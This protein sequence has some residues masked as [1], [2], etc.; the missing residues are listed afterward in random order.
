[1][2]ILKVND[3]DNDPASGPPWPDNYFIRFNRVKGINAESFWSAPDQRDRVAIQE[4][5]DNYDTSW[6]V[7]ALGAGE[8]YTIAWP[9]AP[10]NTTVRV[11]SID[12][13]AEP[14]RAVV[15]LK[16]DD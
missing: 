8:N 6:M 4:Q 2:V 7:A 9:G 10:F 5:A 15:A 1:M 16:R 12:L 14:A 3:P 13:D 11:C